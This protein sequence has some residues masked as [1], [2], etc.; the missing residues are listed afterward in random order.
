MLCPVKKFLLSMLDLAKPIVFFCPG[1]FYAACIQRAYG[2]KPLE[3]MVKPLEPMVK[4]LEPMV[5][6]RSSLSS[7][8]GYTIIDTKSIPHSCDIV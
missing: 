1:I 2:V 6:P 8:D 4:P 3:P 7:R 5:K